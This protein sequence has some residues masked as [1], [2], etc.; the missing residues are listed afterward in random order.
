MKKLDKIGQSGPFYQ[1]DKRRRKAVRLLFEDELTD[2]QIAKAV[3]RRRS[4]LDNWKND[5][6]FKAAQQQYNH[7]VIKKSFESKALKKL[8]D[9][10]EAKSEMV[11]LQ[12]ANSI[13]KLSGMLSDNSTPELDKARIRKANADARV[14]EAR[15]KAME[16]NGQDMELLLD[17]L[18]D[19]VESE[20]QKHGTEQSADS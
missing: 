15:A 11:Q 2:E 13:L 5:E 6:L 4:T 17:K 8:V 7:L 1:L 12:A 18:M 16:D 3:Q 14:A 19:K 9:L 20:D 10:L